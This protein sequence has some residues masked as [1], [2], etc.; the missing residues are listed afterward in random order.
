MPS[1]KT[2]IV[3]DQATEK[4]APTSCPTSKPWQTLSK[5]GIRR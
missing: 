1:P 5:Q 2:Y 3:N 4:D